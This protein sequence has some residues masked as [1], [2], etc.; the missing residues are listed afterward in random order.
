MRIVV[1]RPGALG[2]TLLTFPTLAALR[3]HWPD[4]H[5][6]LVC[7]A[8]VHTLA[9]A[10]EL[11]DRLYSHELATWAWLFGSAMAPAALARESF[12]GADLALVWAPDAENN[13]ASRLRALGVNETLVAAPPPLIGPHQHVALQL[14]GALAPLGVAVAK[15][16]R[17]LSRALP[18]LRWPVEAQEEARTAWKAINQTEQPRIA[19]HPGSGSARKRW[20]AAHLA[21]LLR[22]LQRDCAPVL[23]EGPQDGAVVAEILTQV[24]GVPVVRDLSVA[25]L[26]AFICDCALYVGNDSGATH[27]AGLLG[28]PTVAL[29]GPTDPACWAPLGPHVV[30]LQS[31]T[32][33]L[34]DLPVSVVA[35]AIRKVVGA[36]TRSRDTRCW[37]SKY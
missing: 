21:G 3:S 12:G 19:I 20:P 33:H 32:G 36:N 28:L 5:M 6:T 24:E 35:S 27:L 18:V 23:I 2:D 11:A 37:P 17:A 13:I 16:V 7:R 30:M 8:D 29:F 34:D 15:D 9:L 25:G 14:L 4:A 31:A 10:S 1:Y 26:A 22:D